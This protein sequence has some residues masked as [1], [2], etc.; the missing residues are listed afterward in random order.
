MICRV[1]SLHFS[2]SA[3]SSSGVLTRRSLFR[4]FWR[5]ASSSC[6]D[7][8]KGQRIQAPLWWNLVYKFPACYSIRQTRPAA[9]RTDFLRL[10]LLLYHCIESVLANNNLCAVLAHS[11]LFIINFCAI[12]AQSN[13]DRSSRTLFES[14]SA[15]SSDISGSFV[16]VTGNAT[17]AARNSSLTTFRMSLSEKDGT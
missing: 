8:P 11:D 1:I 7:R 6:R 2:F 13:R 4:Y 16:V 10:I 14:N 15:I 17:A 3:V 12:L 5:T 9:F